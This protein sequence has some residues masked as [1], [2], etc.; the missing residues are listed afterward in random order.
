LDQVP[1]PVYISASVGIAI[2]QQD[3]EVIEELVSYADKAMYVAK[4]T[5]KNRY[6]FYADI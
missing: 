6:V 2:Y 3:S 5:G 4:K 1:K